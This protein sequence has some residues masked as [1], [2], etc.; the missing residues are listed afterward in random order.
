MNGYLARQEVEQLT[1]YS[2]STIERAVA[3]YRATKG[4]R[5]LK[6]VQRVANGPRWFRKTEVQKWV[7]ID[8]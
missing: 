7:G 3:E 8:T 1:G 2:R 6:F 5:G 4:K